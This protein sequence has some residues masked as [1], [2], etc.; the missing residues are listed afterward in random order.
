MICLRFLVLIEI[1]EHLLVKRLELRCRCFLIECLESLYLRQQVLFDGSLV[2]LA[3]PKV[4]GAKVKP[5]NTTGM[6]RWRIGRDRTDMLDIPAL[7][8]EV[9]ELKPMV[10]FGIL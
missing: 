7:L 4:F 6:V 3:G 9:I 1:L 5:F 10:A 2:V 8:F